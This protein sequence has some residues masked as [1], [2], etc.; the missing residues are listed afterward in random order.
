MQKLQPGL[1][2][3]RVSAAQVMCSE[4]IRGDQLRVYTE[5]VSPPWGSHPLKDHS[6]AQAETLEPGGMTPRTQRPPSQGSVTFKDV[7]VD[8]T[9]EE[10]CLLDP[11]QKELFREVVL[12]NVQNLLFVES[13]TNFEEKMSTKL[14]LFVEVCGPPRGMNKGPCDF[15]VREIC[16]S[17]IKVNKNP[18]SDCEFDEVAEKFSQYSILNQYVKLTS[19]NDCCPDSEYT[20][21]FPEKVE[22]NQSHEKAPEMPLYQDNLGRIAYGS[23]L[24]FIRHRK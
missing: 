19:G 5:E 24:D 3:G 14:N 8:F 10:W 18:K 12:E 7:A 17:N 15:I 23:S 11:S 13:E 20:K 16:D 1:L 6:L 9:Q 21:C 2:Q 22:F 4:K